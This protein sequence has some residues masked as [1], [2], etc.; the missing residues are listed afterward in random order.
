M[1]LAK[2]SCNHVISHHV[3][4]QPYGGGSEG[5]F[6]TL[7]ERGR[8]PVAHSLK[9]H[10]R[11]VGPVLIALVWALLC[12]S[13]GHG[14]PVHA[15]EPGSKSV[16]EILAKLDIA[17]ELPVGLGFRQE[18][19]LKALFSTWTFHT[20]VSLG[21]DGFSSETTGAPRFVPDSLAKELIELGRSPSLFELDVIE[22]GE[23][24][25]VVLKGPRRKYQ[26][27]GPARRP[28]GSI[29]DIGSS[30]EPKRPTRGARST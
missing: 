27:T 11:R 21:Q 5:M 14:E 8:S 3:T 15:G 16:A 18:I 9:R 30:T 22:A 10:N 29:H 19:V 6:R 26:G 28:F 25:P 12:G 13:V 20:R 17:A 24:G 2:S 7:T 23:D 4:S 1:R